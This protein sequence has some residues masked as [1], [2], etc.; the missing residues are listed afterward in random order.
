M[1]IKLSQ[2][3]REGAL[4]LVLSTAILGATTE[5]VYHTLIKDQDLETGY[6]LAG[7]SVNN[8]DGGISMTYHS[9]VT[10]ADGTTTN[11]VPC[12]FRSEEE[13]KNFLAQNSKH[14]RVK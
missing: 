3:L 7:N 9:V 13:F 2:R 10:F 5:R 6:E 14:S 11:L 1:A 8:F 4:A 12:D